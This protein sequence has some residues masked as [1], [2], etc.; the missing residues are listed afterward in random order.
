MMMI[1]ALMFST[2]TFFSLRSQTSEED[3][4]LSGEGDGDDND[5]VI[6]DNNNT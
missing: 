1:V 5:V 3:F 6:T 4:Y 2:M